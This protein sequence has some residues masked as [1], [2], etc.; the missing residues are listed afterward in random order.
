MDEADALLVPILAVVN[1]ATTIGATLCAHKNGDDAAVAPADIVAGLIHVLVTEMSEQDMQ[2]SIDEARRIVDDIRQG[3]DDDDG[4]DSEEPD[5]HELEAQVR[6]VGVSTYMCN[7]DVCMT[8]RVAILNFP[9]FQPVSVDQ[10]WVYNAICK[11]AAE[12]EISIEG[13]VEA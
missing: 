12:H 10:S 7:C 6:N 8:T 5:S 4:D 2:S 11:T 3:G 13:V 1:K 9:S